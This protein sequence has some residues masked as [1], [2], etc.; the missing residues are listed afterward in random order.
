MAETPFKLRSGNTTPFKQMGSTPAKHLGRHPSK[1]DGHTSD[2]HKKMG[3]FESLT[4]SKWKDTNLGKDIKDLGTDI[5]GNKKLGTTKRKK[6]EDAA[7]AA[8]LD[9]KNKDAAAN[10][11]E[12][13]KK[14]ATEL[15][16]KRSGS[17]N[18][19]EY[20][21]TDG[22][23]FPSVK[24]RREQYGDES[25]T[26]TK[27]QNIKKLKELKEESSNKMKG[28]P[29]KHP[30]HID[31]HPKAKERIKKEGGKKEGGKVKKAIKE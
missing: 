16:E 13:E 15:K 21:T 2:A 1:K 5:Q 26:G 8:E 31:H 25:Y 30:A 10:K 11:L 19:Y 28:S 6:K 7:A 29:A 22:G 12:Q 9:K 17:T 4:G 27:E 3:L 18:L 24:E 23:E 14:E 20:Y